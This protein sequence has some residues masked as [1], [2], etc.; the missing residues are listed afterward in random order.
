MLPAQSE[1]VTSTATLL[2]KKD[3]APQPVDAQTARK[4]KTLE[5]MQQRAAESAAVLQMRTRTHAGRP[6][7]PCSSPRQ[8]THDQD[9]YRGLC[10]LFQ[11]PALLAATG[12]GAA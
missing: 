10:T 11:R 7:R 5:Q 1:Q 2:S 12:R 3:K 4:N 6:A 9:T 8:H